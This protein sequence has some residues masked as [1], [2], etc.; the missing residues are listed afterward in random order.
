[1]QQGKKPFLEFESRISMGN[2]I[3][4]AFAALALAVT[5]GGLNHRTDTLSRDVSTNKAAI[6]SNESR[7]R[8]LEQSMAR[9][10]E[11]LILILDGLRKIEKQIENSYFPRRAD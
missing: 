8:V 4:L 11:R 3:V 1:M 10:D 9:Q 5:W 6:A 2:L 7:V